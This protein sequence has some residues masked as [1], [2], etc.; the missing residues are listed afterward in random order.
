MMPRDWWEGGV[1]RETQSRVGDSVPNTS[2]HSQLV[3]TNHQFLGL[4]SDN[5]S[6]IRST[7]TNRI[8][9]HS[10]HYYITYYS[11]IHLLY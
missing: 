8:H 2:P 5:K 11:N 1:L 7:W 3:Y 6:E 10:E 4:K 9:G